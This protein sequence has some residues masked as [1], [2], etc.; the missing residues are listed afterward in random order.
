MKKI[1]A[2]ILTITI[3]SSTLNVLSFADNDDWNEASAP[4]FS[5]TQYHWGREYV[6]KLEMTNIISGYPDGTFK[7]D[8]DVRVDEFLVLCIKS[9]SG[10]IEDKNTEDAWNVHWIE[11]GIENGLV[12]ANFGDFTRSITREEMA[13]MAIRT[14]DAIRAKENK[15]PVSIDNEEGLIK[16]I[17]DFDYIKDSNQDAVLKN[18][19]Y[20]LTNGMPD[21]RFYPSGTATR[22]EASVIVLRLVREEERKPYVIEEEV[23]EI[24]KPSNNVIPSSLQKRFDDIEAIFGLTWT[25]AD[26]EAWYNETSDEDK[27]Y[28]FNQ[29]KAPPVFNFEERY[30]LLAMGGQQSHV[31]K[32]LQNLNDYNDILP[33]DY[34]GSIAYQMYKMNI[35][36]FVKDGE[37]YGQI[38][39][40]QNLE[41]DGLTIEIKDITKSG[42]WN[43][44]SFRTVITTTSDSQGALFHH[45][46]KDQWDKDLDDINWTTVEEHI[47]PYVNSSTRL[48]YLLLHGVKEGQVMFNNYMDAFDQR[49]LIGGNSTPNPKLDI[50]TENYTIRHRNFAG[51]WLITELKEKK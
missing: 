47:T 1:I 25:D 16:E 6:E 17:K 3:M 32:N 4:I 20:G 35:E 31:Q 46:L 24:P 50:E 5:D 15:K 45:Y 26:F 41:N 10:E 11:Y 7:P 39:I 28:Y 23:V 12:D 43:R 38:Y 40:T 44:C 22:A 33:L 49:M 29:D 21:K 36:M 9:L 48:N 42:Y 37:D 30:V 14:L 51:W 34:F 2:L 19:S 13:Q 27:N 8:N 18:Y